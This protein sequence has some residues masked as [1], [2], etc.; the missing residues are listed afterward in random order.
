MDPHH[1]LVSQPAP[2]AL[3]TLY[4]EAA[5]WPHIRLLAALRQLRVALALRK[6]TPAAMMPRNPLP[7]AE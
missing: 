4:Q 7:A 5:T 2:I 6:S 1:A 3:E